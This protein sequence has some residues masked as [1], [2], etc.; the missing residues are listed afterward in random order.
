MTEPLK[1][2][3]LEWV[4]NGPFYD[5]TLMKEHVRSHPKPTETYTAEELEAMDIVGWYRKKN[6]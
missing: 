3:D 2:S 1:E 5:Y 4:V 6:A